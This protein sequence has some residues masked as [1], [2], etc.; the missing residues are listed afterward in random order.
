MYITFQKINKKK[1]KQLNWQMGKRNKLAIER[2]KK[3]NG[4]WAHEKSF[5]LT[6]NQ[7]KSKLNKWNT[8]F[9]IRC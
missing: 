3:V 5:N 6:N 9:T 2:R 8:I 4:Q 7:G 1:G